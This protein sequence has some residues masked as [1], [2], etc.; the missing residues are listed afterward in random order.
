ML[1]C[2]CK[3]MNAKRELKYSTCFAISFGHESNLEVRIGKL[4]FLMRRRRGNESCWQ[5]RL[6]KNGRS[7]KTVFPINLKQYLFVFFFLDIW[8]VVCRIICFVIEIEESVELRAK[9]LENWKI[10]KHFQPKKLKL[11]CDWKE[12]VLF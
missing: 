2:E 7:E 3:K 6:G 12:I 9:W 4:P 11:N 10:E 1:L 8:S 5:S